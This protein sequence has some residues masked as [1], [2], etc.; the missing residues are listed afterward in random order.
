MKYIKI[1]QNFFKNINFIVEIPTI[2]CPVCGEQILDIP[3][4]RFIN[5]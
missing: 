4:N 3:T 5:N 1:D 2:S